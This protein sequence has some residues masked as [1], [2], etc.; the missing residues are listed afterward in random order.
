[1]MK[2]ILSFVY[3]DLK[4]IR[5]ELEMNFEI[6]PISSLCQQV[7]GRVIIY[8]FQLADP[9]IP[10]IS[11]FTVLIRQ[12]PNNTFKNYWDA[13]KNVQNMML[14]LVDVVKKVWEPAFKKCCAFLESLRDKSITLAEVD[15]L[16]NT[17]PDEK[18]KFEIKQLEKG[19]C[20]CKNIK[21]LDNKWIESCVK[22]MWEYHSLRRH[23]SAAEAFLSLKVTLELTGDFDIVEKL[24]AEVSSY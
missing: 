14:Q 11:D 1:M 10:I 20:H 2:K 3:V 6:K 21:V 5:E 13:E 24:A 17:Y 4:D 7:E 8:C 12:Y 16:L 18:L 22:R 19:I 9:F 15:E 23:T